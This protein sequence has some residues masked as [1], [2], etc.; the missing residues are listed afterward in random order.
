MTLKRKNKPEKRVYMVD[1]DVP[2]QATTGWYTIDIQD[3]NGR[4]SSAKDYVIMARLER[5]TE[6]SPA[7]DE[8]VQLPVTLK[9]KP[10]IGAQ[11]YEVFVRDIWTENQVFKSKLTETAELKIPDNKLEPGGSYSWTVHAR[12]TNEHILLGDFGAGSMSDKAFFTVA[13]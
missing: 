10:V 7:D 8:Q 13:E 6:M 2:D 11:H 1:M 12:D 4:V 3:V 9:W 5:V